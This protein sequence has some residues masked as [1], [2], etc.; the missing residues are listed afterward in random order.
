[1]RPAFRS[2]CASK[3]GPLATYVRRWPR[4]SASSRTP[5]RA[6][7]WKGRPRARAIDCP[8]DVFPVPGGPTNLQFSRP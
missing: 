4:I 1:M 7:R 2:A 3:P 5:P 8:N 6:I